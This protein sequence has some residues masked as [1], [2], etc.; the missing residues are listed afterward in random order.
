MPVDGAELVAGLVRAI[1]RYVVLPAHETLIVVL[2]TIHA[3]CFD[4][5][6]IIRTVG[7]NFEPRAFSTHSPL[8][9]AQIGKRHSALAE[10]AIFPKWRERRLDGLPTM[11]M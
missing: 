6:Q 3:F 5:F 8:A 1:R 4:S 9:I 11:P 7:D 2:W 10:P